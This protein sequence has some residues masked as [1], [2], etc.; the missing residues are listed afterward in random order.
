VRRAYLIDAG[1]GRYYVSIDRDGQGLL[2]GR[3]GPYVLD[4]GRLADRLRGRPAPGRMT[5]PVM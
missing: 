1:S 2:Q 3:H 5:R 4:V